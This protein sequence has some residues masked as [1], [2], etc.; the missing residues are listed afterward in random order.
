MAIEIQFSNDVT[1]AKEDTH[2][3]DGRLN[4]SAR[5][6]GRGYYVSRDDQLSFSLVWRSTLN[7]AGSFPVYWQN[8]D[9]DK[10]LVIRSVGVNAELTST[11]KLHA[12]TGT[13]AGGSSLT[14]ACL[15][16][17]APRVAA[18]ISRGNGLITGLTSDVEIDHASVVAN[19]HE[20]FRLQNE[21]RLGQ[22]GAIAIELDSGSTGIIFGVLFGRYE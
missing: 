13:A 21:L 1:N 10:H 8:T 6:D 19:G 11:F 7:D 12:V 20:E 16:R 18:A 3:S 15:N 9:T 17:A 5:I 14:P 2:G 22:N 4:V